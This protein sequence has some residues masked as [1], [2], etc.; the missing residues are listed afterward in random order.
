MSGKNFSVLLGLLSVRL[1]PEG[2]FGAWGF[3][4]NDLPRRPEGDRTTT[5]FQHKPLLV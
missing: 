1:K 4:D 2:E 3:P 5:G